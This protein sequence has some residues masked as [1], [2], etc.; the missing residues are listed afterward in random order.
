MSQT[1]VNSYKTK[2]RE[3][4]TKRKGEL[5]ETRRLAYGWQFYV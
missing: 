4:K 5:E 2:D 1:R 3:K